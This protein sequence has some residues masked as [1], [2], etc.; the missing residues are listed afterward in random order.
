MFK[1]VR[2]CRTF[3]NCMYLLFGIS[4]AMNEGSCFSISTIVVVFSVFVLFFHFNGVERTYYGFYSYFPINYHYACFHMLVSCSLVSL[5]TYMHEKEL[6]GKT[7]SK[8]KST[9][10]IKGKVY[11]W[12]GCVGELRE[13]D[14]ETEGKRQ[15]QRDGEWES[16]SH[17][18][19]LYYELLLLRA[20]TG[21]E[22]LT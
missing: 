15:R 14:R 21:N 17:Q 13:R 18:G 11:I 12:E 4:T 9:R 5:I 16:Q 10:F 2:N 20:R 1:L 19:C 8:Q 22:V 6:K 7:N 3:L